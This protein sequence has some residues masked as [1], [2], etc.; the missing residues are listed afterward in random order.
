MAVNG[1]KRRLLILLVFALL[2]V[3]AQQVI[4]RLSPP[5]EIFIVAQDAQ[6]AQSAYPNAQVV[7]P[8]PEELPE[9]VNLNTATVEQLEELPGLSSRMAQRVVEYREEQ[10][11]F[12]S[13]DELEQVYGIGPATLEKLR[14]Y[15]TVD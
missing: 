9:P 12:Q 3:L 6:E 7:T 1:D 8:S 13:V 10:G 4:S 15:V 2:L 5:V 11:E 14:P